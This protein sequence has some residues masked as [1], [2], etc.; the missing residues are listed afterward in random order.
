[1]LL[2]TNGRSL[3]TSHSSVLFLK[4]RIIGY[5]IILTFQPPTQGSDCSVCIERLAT[6]WTALRSNPDEGGFSALLQT[7]PGVQP[8][9][10]TMRTGPLPGLMRPGRGVDH[11]P[12]YSVEV[13]ERV[14]IHL[15][16][17][18]A[19]VA[20]SRVNFKLFQSPKYRR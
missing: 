18:W 8:S 17:L 1:M 2:R 10:Y 19:F 9:S 11:P 4:W 7:D 13:K 15:R 16:P 20:C 14:V 3:G 6:G 5:T 12:S